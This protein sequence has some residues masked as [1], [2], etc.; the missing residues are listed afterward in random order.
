QDLKSNSRNPNSSQNN[1]DFEQ[2][3]QEI[4]ERNKRKRN[5]ILYGLP[6]QDQQL[7]S[8]MRIEKDES[9]VREIISSMD[10]A[11][12]IDNFKPIRLGRYD[13]GKVRPVRITL[14]HDN[15]VFVAMKNAKSL[16]TGRYKHIQISFDRT[17]KQ[18]QYFKEVKAELDAKN[19]SGTEKYKIRHVDGIPKIVPI[20]LN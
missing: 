3:I 1:V 17:L 8:V 19:A 5:L 6:E 14:Q 20:N 4:N 2:V 10:H 18:R 12:V 7:S 11:L 16:K 13:E 15:D 9:Q